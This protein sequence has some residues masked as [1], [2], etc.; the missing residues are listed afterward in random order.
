MQPKY[1]ILITAGYNPDKIDPIKEITGVHHKVLADV[2]GKTAS[3]G[4]VESRT[5]GH[6]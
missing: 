6:L 2:G 3:R 1:D 5:G 4:L